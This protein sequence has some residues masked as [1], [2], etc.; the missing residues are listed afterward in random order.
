MNTPHTA[1]LLQETIE[2]LDLQPGSVVVD[3]TVGA[4]GHSLLMSQQIGFEGI[5]IGFDADKNALD[6]AKEVL[7]TGPAKFI[8][9]ES[10]FRHLTTKLAEIG[11]GEVDAILFDLGVSSMQL[12]SGQR[13]FSFRFNEPLLMTLKTEPGADDLT[14]LD[15]VTTL[16]AKDLAI[17]LKNYGEEQFAD[18][19]ATAI[20]EARRTAPIDTTFRLIEIIESVVPNWYKKRRLH[21]ATKTFQALR[22]AT[23]DELGSLEEGL[24]GAWQMLKIDGRLAVISFHSLEAKIVKNFYKDKKTSGL[25]EI[26]SKKVIR[27]SRTEVVENKRSRSASLRIIRKLSDS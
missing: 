4:G 5:V 9:I 11:I 16:E 24:A 26:I 22:I 14:A 2:G 23:N 27:P 7:A 21:P 20:V 1:V 10:N 17:I 3:A 13:G 18:K 12:D 25:G 6:L 8:P 15:L 19:I